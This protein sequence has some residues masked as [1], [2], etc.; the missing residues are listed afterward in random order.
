MIAVVVAYAFVVHSVSRRMSTHHRRLRGGGAGSVSVGSSK[1]AIKRTSGNAN[2]VSLSS[3]SGTAGHASIS[4]SDRVTPRYKYIINNKQS[5]HTHPA[6]IN[7]NKRNTD[8]MYLH[9]TK[10]IN[11]RRA[12][13]VSSSPWRKIK[14]HR[15]VN[16]WGVAVD[17]INK[18]GG[19]RGRR[20]AIRMQLCDE[21]GV[22]RGCQNQPSLLEDIN[23]DQ[24]SRTASSVTHE[25]KNVSN[26]ASCALFEHMN[27]YPLESVRRADT[28]TVPPNNDFSLNI[29]SDTARESRL[30]NKSDLDVLN[31]PNAT[32]LTMRE[33]KCDDKENDE[34]RG[35]M[36][37]QVLKKAPMTTAPL[38]PSR[39]PN[40]SPRKSSLP[41]ARILPKVSKRADMKPAPPSSN[42]A[43][44]PSTSTSS[45][46]TNCESDSKQQ[47][48]VVLVSSG[49]ADY[50]QKANQKAALN[51]LGD[52]CLP[53]ETVDGVD[54]LEREKRNKFFQV[55]GVRGNYPQLFVVGGDDDCRYLGG[56]DWL[57]SQHF[58]NLT[59]IVGQTE[60]M[61]SSISQSESIQRTAV[62][63]D[64]NTA[65]LTV[66]VSIGVVD[67]QQAANQTALMNL[68][69]DL[70]IPY[71]LVDGM[72]PMQREER[73][74][75]F[76]I[77]GVR[78]QYPQIFTSSRE[79]LGGFDWLETQRIEDL[80][81][82]IG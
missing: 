15:Q 19:W 55:S 18:R 51:L 34:S 33:N 27:S 12:K 5:I 64:T 40:S 29:V 79:Y 71:K 73:D 3:R 48:L 36:G 75:F 13:R 49:L 58:N 74:A 60:V 4:S 38:S 54:P 78:G 32:T 57:E 17:A 35:L 52:L 20:L 9:L 82:L 70:R 24:G 42:H 72:D 68:F 25:K 10:N 61:A 31:V 69:H 43:N 44:S 37:T 80:K 67:Y 53:Y 6:P 65:A 22:G 77:S 41:I 81:A 76:A 47:T 66:L 16:T 8:K 62:A 2:N 63:T 59:K 56:Y 1:G 30:P 28:D 39:S 14:P 45:L 23:Q 26:A 46:I 21:Y 7:N 11:D 50:T